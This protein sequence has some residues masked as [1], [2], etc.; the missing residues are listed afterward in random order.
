MRDTTFDDDKKLMLI[1]FIFRTI[2]V[3]LI[4]LPSFIATGV[5][6]SV[7]KDYRLTVDFMENDAIYIFIKNLCFVMYYIIYLD[8]YIH[9]RDGFP[10]T[11]Y[12]GVCFDAIFVTMLTLYNYDSFIKSMIAM[13]FPVS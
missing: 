7:T 1:R 10:K 5:I 4:F 6:A 9:T 8:N 13:I 3:F 2:L 11:L 12:I